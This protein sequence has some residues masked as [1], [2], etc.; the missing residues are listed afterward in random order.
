V[1]RPRLTYFEDYSFKFNTE[2]AAIISRFEGERKQFVAAIMDHCHT[3]KIW[4]SVDIPAI[5]TNPAA[6]RQRIIAALEYFDEHGWIELQSKQAV[7]VYDILTRTFDLDDM[8]AKMDALFKRKEQAEIQRIHDMV[9]FFESDACLSRQ[10]AGYF[11]EKIAKARCGHCSFCKGGKV[12]LQN[13]ADLKPLS[14]F[15]FSELTTEFRQAVGEHFSNINL[16][17]FLCGIYTP[18]FSKLKI[19]T[20]P[21]FG[22]LENYPF[23]EVKNWILSNAAKKSG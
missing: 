19:K 13:T 7:E 11:G 23:L 6:D 1:I 20:L 21:H 17:K 2:P 14:N 22:I 10:L 5:L 12:V 15:K 8:T 9:G 4:T 18:V 16:T 3:H